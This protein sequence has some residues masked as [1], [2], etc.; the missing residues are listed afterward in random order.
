MNVSVIFPSRSNLAWLLIG[1]SVGLSAHAASLSVTPSS[2]SNTYAGQITL[3]ITGLNNGETVRIERF[4]DV[5]SNG[6][7]DTNDWLFSSFLVTDGQVT[8]FGGV[9]N[10]NIPGDDDAVTGH[11][12][13]SVSFPNSP[14]LSRVAGTELVR[15]SSPTNR[16]TPVVQ[17]FTVTQFAYSQSVTGTVTSGS[18]SVPYAGVGLLVLVGNDAVFLEGAL[19]DAAGHFSLHAAPS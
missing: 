1:F 14:E 9:R 7:I 17:P 18:S 19:A 12:T 15:V 13:T 8:S 10:A 2:V 16:F 3:Q 6:L 4:V 5:N 11:I